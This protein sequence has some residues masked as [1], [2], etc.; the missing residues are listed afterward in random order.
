MDIHLAVASSADTPEDV[1]REYREEYSEQL[2]KL[3]A[4]ITPDSD[5]AF[6]VVLTGGA[7]NEILAA[8]RRYN[9]L[10]AW[11][12]YN[13]LPSA[14]E[15]LAALRDSGRYAKLITLERPGQP[16]DERAVRAL[17]LIE[18]IKRGAP[19]FGLVGAPNSWL[20]SSNM[21]L[22]VV[23]QIGLEESLAGLDPRTGLE[24]ARKLI[25]GAISSEFSEAQIAPM[26]A[27]AKRLAEMAEKRGWDGLTLGCWCFDREAIRRL[28][29]TPCISLALLNQMG[30]PAACEGDMRALYSMY[31][32]SRLSGG[33]A[34]MG[35]VNLAEGDLLVLTHDGAPPMIA[36]KY[37]IVKRMG[38]GAPAAIRAAFA[39]GLT[40]TL[41]RVSADLK[42]AL[43]LKGVTV[44]AERI[45]ACNTQIGLKLLVGSAKDVLEAGLGN[46]LAFVLDDVYDEVKEYLTYMGAKVVP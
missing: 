27:Y 21:V 38:T 17:R 1:K 3:G 10:L 24:D 25:S 8:S 31:V 43:L 16:L 26:A 32:L 15:A 41:L 14:L 12:H 42:R 23:D 22:V 7:E 19:R 36:D 20:V 9:V 11:P 35:N 29:W 5:T 6:I 30:I 46:H 37:S 2:T 28:G 45:E 44:E 13:S 34:W 39:S 18:L 33:P 4:S 40:A